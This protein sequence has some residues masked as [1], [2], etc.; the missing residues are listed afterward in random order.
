MLIP[1]KYYPINFKKQEKQQ[2]LKQNKEKFEKELKE[3]EAKSPKQ[4]L[5]EEVKKVI[6]EGDRYI[7][8]IRRSN[9]AI[10]GVEISNK[11]YHK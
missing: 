5:S 7:E 6:E 9:D 11:I 2:N 10:P 8:E 1:L 3:K 4:Q